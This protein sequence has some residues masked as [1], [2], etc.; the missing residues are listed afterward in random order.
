MFS[1]GIKASELIKLLQQQIQL[2]G[3]LE[4]IAGGGDYPEGIKSVQYE[5]K[6]DA[7]TPKNSFKI[8]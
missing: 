7:Y 3:D 8:W 5:A 4:V 2:H 6:G 1:H